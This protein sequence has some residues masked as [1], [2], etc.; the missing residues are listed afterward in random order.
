V[1]N[2]P[3]ARKNRV[4][5]AQTRYPCGSSTDLELIAQLKSQL[6]YAEL[7]IRVLEERLRQLF[8]FLLH[9][10]IVPMSVKVPVALSMLYMETLFE[11]EFV[12]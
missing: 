12:T 1:L 11:P 8:F 2:C 4:V 7:T 10:P 9:V 5:R 3:H 6:Q